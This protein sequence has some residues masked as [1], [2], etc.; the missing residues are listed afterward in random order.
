MRLAIHN[1]INH[2]LW[3]GVTYGVVGDVSD[4]VDVTH[5]LS[6]QRAEFKKYKDYTVWL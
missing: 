5:L 2:S 4:G 1:L 6:D 3:L